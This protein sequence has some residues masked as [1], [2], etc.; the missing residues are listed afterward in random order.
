MANEQ[1]QQQ[2]GEGRTVTPELRQQRHESRAGSTYKAFLRDVCSIGDFSE[3]L[4][5]CAAVSVLCGLERRVLGDEAADLSAQ[6][7]FK[8]REL[9][10]RCEIHQGKPEKFG[11]EEF[12]QSVAEDLKKD[13]GEVEPIIRAVVTAVRAQVSEGEAEQFG[14]MLPHDLRDLWARPS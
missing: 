12:F 9:L 6:L 8:L 11:R 10:Q 3:E 1:N 13:V 5:E 4:A 7:P 2:Q 14:S